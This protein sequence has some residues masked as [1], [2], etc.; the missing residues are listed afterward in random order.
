MP[1][2]ETPEP[3]DAKLPVFSVKPEHEE[4][5]ASILPAYLAFEGEVAAD[6]SK[7]EKQFKK[8][9]KKDWIEKHVVKKLVA[10]FKLD[11]KYNMASVREVRSLACDQA[12][13]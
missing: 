3:A 4:F 7:R 6:K 12:Y 1:S 11:K 13:I 5:M 2:S 8:G 10:E 9:A